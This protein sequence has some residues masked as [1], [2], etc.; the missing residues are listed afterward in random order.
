MLILPAALFAVESGKG[1]T[2]QGTYPPSEVYVVVSYQGVTHPKVIG[3]A[4]TGELKVVGISYGREPLVREVQADLAVE[5][6]S[7]LLELDF[8]S[9]KESY[10]FRKGAALLDEAGTVTLVETGSP[11]RS[12]VKIDLHIGERSHEVDLD[13]TAPAAPEALQGWVAELRKLVVEEFEL[14]R[15]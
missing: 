3:L 14:D 9:L 7:R 10:P 15:F 11:D 13:F 6:V 5:M 12:V 8:F 1:L 2:Y 4:C